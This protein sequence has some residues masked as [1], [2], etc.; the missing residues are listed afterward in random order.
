MGTRMVLN[1][2]RD[3][4]AIAKAFPAA[5]PAVHEMLAQVPKIQQA[6]FASAKPA[7]PAA[8]PNA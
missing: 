5:S 2:V 7:E 4:R 6:M 1:V 8:P 3:L